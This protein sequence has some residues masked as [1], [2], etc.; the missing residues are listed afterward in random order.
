MYKLLIADDEYWIR[1]NLRNMLDWDRLG[2]ELCEPA[3]DGE[4][5]LQRVKSEKPEILMTDINMPFISGVELIKEAKSIQPEIVAI[6]LSGFSDYEYVRETLLAGAI[7]YLLKPI[8]KSAFEDIINKALSVIHAQTIRNKE[9]EDT[10]RHLTLARSI[11]RDREFS[12]LISGYES[13]EVA[14]PLALELELRFAEFTLLL[15]RFGKLGNRMNEALIDQIRSTLELAA[16]VRNSFVFHNIY[17][18]NEFIL[19]GGV[20]DYVALCENLLNGLSFV[21]GII[22]IGISRRYFSFAKL[23]DA[24]DEAAYAL[25]ARKFEP[26]SA[27]LHIEAV[28]KLHLKKHIIP[29]HEKE[30]SAYVKNRDKRGLQRLVFDEIG[31]RYCKGWMFAEVKRAAIQF[32]FLIRQEISDEKLD[33]RA[34]AIDSLVETLSIA[35]ENIDLDEIC[36]IMNQIIDEAVSIEENDDMDSAQKTIQKL[37]QYIDENYF[38]SMSLGALAQKFHVEQSYLSRLFKREAG[39]NL[40]HYINLKRI[41]KAKEY[42]IEQN[43]HLSEISFLVGYDDYT[44]FSRV[45]RKITGKSP[46]EYARASH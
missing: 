43:R 2:I 4:E 46:S 13:H 40:I 6:T 34:L 1:E 9:R 38:E 22:G 28:Q 27:V 14:S 7:D 23:R 33:S 25:S 31:L 41:E 19:L 29:Q 26:S 20:D 5:A 21:S 8:D 17:S 12:S 30:L 10:K 18:P 39:E 37:I 42:I 35:V 45:F 44:Y 32:S 36:G 15:I 24:Y 3:C 11:L 16:D